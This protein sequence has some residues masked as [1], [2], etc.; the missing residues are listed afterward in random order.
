MCRLSSWRKLVSNNVVNFRSLSCIAHDCSVEMHWPF[1]DEG[2][3][4]TPYRLPQQEGLAI[5]KL[6]VAV[7]NHIKAAYTT[8]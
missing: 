1:P 2:S 6:E 5:S 8:R 7:R 4:Q 3:F